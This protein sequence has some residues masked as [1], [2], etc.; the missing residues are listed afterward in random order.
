MSDLTSLSDASGQDDPFLTEL[1]EF[2]YLP[3]DD[4]L[5]P[6]LIVRACWILLKPHP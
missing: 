2:N 4:P 3:D 5:V 1:P 6:F